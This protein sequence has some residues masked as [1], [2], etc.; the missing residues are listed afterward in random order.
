MTIFFVGG[1]NG[2]RLLNGLWCTRDQ[3]NTQWVLD[4]SSPPIIL[5]ADN[6]FHLN[7]RSEKKSSLVFSNF[8]PVL[9]SFLHTVFV[10]DKDLEYPIHRLFQKM[11]V[12]RSR[13]D[14]ARNISGVERLPEDLTSKA[15]V[16]GFKGPSCEAAAQYFADLV[17]HL[18]QLLEVVEVE[19]KQTAKQFEESLSNNQISFDLLEYYYE[20]GAWYAHNLGIE[21]NDVDI[22][23]RI[24]LGILKRACFRDE[25]E[26]LA[27]EIESFEWDGVHFLKHTNTLVQ[28]AYQGTREISSLVLQRMTNETLAQVTE[29]GRFYISYSRVWHAVYYDD[30]RTL[31]PLVCSDMTLKPRMRRVMIDPVGFHRAQSG[32]NPNISVPIP[33]NVEEYIALLPFWIGGY[34]LEARVS[35]LYILLVFGVHY[36]MKEWRTFR[37]WD[38]KPVESDQEGWRK[39]IMDK[40]TKDII[41][42]LLDTTGRSLGPPHPVQLSKG[43][44][45]LLSGLPGTGRMTAVHAVC[46]LFKR[47]LLTIS[48]RDFPDNKLDLVPRNLIVPYIARHVSLAATWN[49]VIVVKDADDFLKPKFQRDRNFVNAA[50]SQF[51]SYDCIAFWVS[52]TCDKDFLKS[53]TAVVDFP[54]LDAAARRRL[55]LS[56]F[57]HDEPVRILSN[58]SEHTL[59][60][61]SSGDQKKVD[62]LAHLRDIEK[63]SW[64]QLDMLLGRMIENI[65]VS[66]RALATSNREHLSS[67]HVKVVLK[68]QRLDNLPLW[69]K[70]TR[71]LTLPERVLRTSVV[72]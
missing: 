22:K 10:D 39:L 52:T 7:I 68:A 55:W 35:K 56:H 46:N 3:F 47:P 32:Y 54:E 17:A 53:F 48:A 40:D 42:A 2:V 31:D 50:L 51:E 12:L 72:N 66:A 36:D 34:D 37:V 30:T 63:L 9:D 24:N 23:R 60:S 19:C 57:G 20:E 27:L 67:H 13:L 26:E 11:K 61:S 59:V 64:Y 21:N 18:E 38:L 28:K 25:K 65:M 69:R 44:N 1:R 41:R 70:L 58:N 43:K 62:Y 16:F 33:D 14:D 15:E 71:F 5:D 4:R 45:V 8:S 29:R 49:A 6:Y